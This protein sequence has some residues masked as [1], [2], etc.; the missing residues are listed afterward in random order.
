MTDF[1]IG[2]RYGYE[3]ELSMESKKFLVV[4]R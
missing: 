2:P 1:R 3:V 4:T